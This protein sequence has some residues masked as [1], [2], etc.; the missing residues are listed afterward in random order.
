MD[1]AQEKQQ[2]IEALQTRNEEWLILA[3]KRLLDIDHPP[4]SEEHKS[5]IEERMAAYKTKTDQVI[6]LEELKQSF[7][8][9]GR[10]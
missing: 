6:S 1:I 7:T 8:Q 9:E 3:L 10:L 2:I 4:F 5:I